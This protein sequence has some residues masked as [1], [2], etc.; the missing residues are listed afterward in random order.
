MFSTNFG[1]KGA[2]RSLLRNYISMPFSLHTI[3][4]IFGISIRYTKRPSEYK[5]NKKE[6][7]LNCYD[8]G[9]R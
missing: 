3:L 7:S 1:T 9:T 5:P 2:I 6:Q 4:S 8:T